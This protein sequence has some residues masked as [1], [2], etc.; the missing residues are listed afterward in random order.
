M[1]SEPT[2]SAPRVLEDP[3][4]LDP[5]E[6][7]IGLPIGTD[8][9]VPPLPESSGVSARQVLE[10]ELIPVLARPPCVV[11]FSGGRDSSAMLALATSV[12]RREGLPDPIAVTWRFPAHPSTDE[13]RWQEQ[14][15]SDLRLRD[16]E[17]LDF[18]EEL[19]VLGE[20]ATGLLR[21][22]GQLWPTTAHLI[23]P[24]L[25]HA[26][27]GSLLVSGQLRGL[28]DRW[29]F[30]RA[31]DVIRGRVRPEPRDAGRVAVA[32]LPH[33]VRMRVGRANTASRFPWLRPQAQR[34]LFERLGGPFNIPRRWDRW[35]AWFGSQRAQT[36]AEKSLTL[37][38]REHAVEPFH[39]LRSQALLAALAHEGGAWGLG[40]RPGIMKQLFG[41]LVPDEVL[42]RPR[43]R[44]EYGDVLWASRSRAFAQS[45][46]GSGLD[47]DLVDIEYLRELWTGPRPWMYYSA[48]NVAQA[49]WLATMAPGR[50]GS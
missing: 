41:G 13:S 35:L 30:A 29:R 44:A 26:H 43:T 9:A 32:L 45:W 14:V 22:H 2:G 7:A 46:D 50:A 12:A 20:V 47:H 42:N 31:S 8:P 21:R 6:L 1:S 18:D 38:A 15:I 34:M 28:L 10:A 17:I 25:A 5:L 19:E 16:W 40:G 39:P 11:S 4:D 33:N 37:L 48:A 24:A 23:V 49:A 36:L 27:G 3:G